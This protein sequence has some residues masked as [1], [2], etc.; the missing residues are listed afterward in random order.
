MCDSQK[1]KKKK[2]Q[3]KQKGAKWTSNTSLQRCNAVDSVIIIE[4]RV[5][6]ADVITTTLSWSMWN[7]VI[8]FQHHTCVLCS[9]TYPTTTLTLT[10]TLTFVVWW[11]TIKTPKAMRARVDPCGVSVRLWSY[12][13]PEAAALKAG[14]SLDTNWVIE[15]ECINIVGDCNKMENV[16][17]LWHVHSLNMRWV[18]WCVLHTYFA[19]VI[20]HC[21]KLDYLCSHETCLHRSWY[22][23]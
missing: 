13:D 10:W 23:S 14:V 4:D 16:S 12:P 7:D 19:V 15:V 6:I 21:L 18:L 1:K 11:W 8:H 2:K 17:N 20:Q 22:G 3:T 5:M 9:D